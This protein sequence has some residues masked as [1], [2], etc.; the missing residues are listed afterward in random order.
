MLLILRESELSFLERG[1]RYRPAG[2]GVGVDVFA[3]TRAELEAM[4]AAGNAFV[5]QALRE[6]ISLFN[7]GSRG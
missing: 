3:Y 7:S 4:L 1:A 5:T 6:G 2:V